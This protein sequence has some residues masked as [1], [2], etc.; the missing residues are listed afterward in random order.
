MQDNLK[1]NSLTENERKIERKRER[2]NESFSMSDHNELIELPN[3][4]EI[5]VSFTAISKLTNISV[6]FSK[7]FDDDGYLC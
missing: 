7:S 4:R 2:E 1:F 5:V 6:N 3:W